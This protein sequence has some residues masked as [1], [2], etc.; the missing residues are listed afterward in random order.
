LFFLKQQ[1]FQYGDA[2]LALL[3]FRHKLHEFT[4]IEL[5]KIC[6]ICGKKNKKNSKPQQKLEFGILIPI[7]IGMEFIWLTN[8]IDDFTRN[9]N[10]FVWCFTI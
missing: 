3:S 2:I 7:A 10:Y 1:T 8:Q 4:R 9:D 5:V 6:E